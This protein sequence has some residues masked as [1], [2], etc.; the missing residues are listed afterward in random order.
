MKTA[1][2]PPNNIEDDSDDV[3]NDYSDDDGDEQSE[4]SDDDGDEQSESKSRKNDDNDLQRS[5][6][7]AIEVHNNNVEVHE[8]AIEVNNN[9]VEVEVH[10]TNQSLFLQNSEDENN[11]TIIRANNSVHNF[12]EE[13]S[14]S[15][16][17]QMSFLRDQHVAEDS[18]NIMLHDFHSQFEG[19]VFKTMQKK[20]HQHRL[21]AKLVLTF[22]VLKKTLTI[23][24]PDLECKAKTAR[25][26]IVSKES[27]NY[28]LSEVV[29]I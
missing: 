24:I 15:F 10:N 28:R 2:I 13:L 27:K 20:Q 4:S 21:A 25:E 6:E 29:I 12:E 16:D 11:S 1:T 22:A 3:A 9:N 14:S 7:S 8:S 18:Y 17:D 26:S 5:I 23:V 19:M